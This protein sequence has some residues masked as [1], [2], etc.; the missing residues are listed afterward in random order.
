MNYP[1]SGGAY[2]GA[3]Q[4]GYGGGMLPHDFSHHPDEEESQM[5]ED[6]EEH[7]LSNEN[8]TEQEEGD[9]PSCSDVEGEDGQD[10]NPEGDFE[11]VVSSR[12]PHHQINNEVDENEST[13]KGA[14]TSSLANKQ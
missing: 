1:G 5:L 10:Q 14:H 8:G 12:R 13:H 6:N 4:L 9:Q 11:S 7:Q 2:Q 3:M